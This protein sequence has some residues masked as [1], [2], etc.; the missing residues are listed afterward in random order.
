MHIPICD[1]IIVP[2]AHRLDERHVSKLILWPASLV[3]LLALSIG[4][5]YVMHVVIEKPSLKI[6]GWLA[7]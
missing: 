1:R 5:A 7:A 4:L 6:R 2:I 3:V